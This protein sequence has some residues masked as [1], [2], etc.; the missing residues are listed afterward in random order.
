MAN[1][2]KFQ[3]GVSIACAETYFT[4]CKKLPPQVLRDEITFREKFM[5]DPTARGLNYERIA[6][7]DDTLRSVRVNGSYRAIVKTPS[8]DAKNVYTLLW[9][10]SHDEA[11]TWASKKHIG[12]NSV[13]NAIEIYDVAEKENILPNIV[14]DSAQPKLFQHITDD[15][16]EKLGIAINLIWIIRAAHS[17]GDLEKIKSFLPSQAFEYLTYLN[18]GF[19]IEEIIEMAADKPKEESSAKSYEDAVILQQNSKKFYIVDSDESATELN[20]VL[21]APLEEWRI[22]LHP[23]QKAIV[24]KS[25][26]GPA[27]IL[28]GAGTGKTVVAMH[29]A[30]WLAE[31][32]CAK[33]SDKIL[34]TTFTGNLADDIRA[35]LKLL[36][37]SKILEK[38]EV[39][40]LDKWVFDF[41]KKNRTGERLV[42]GAE[43][44]DYWQKAVNNTD[45]DNKLPI[46]FYMDE[47]E[48]IV[49]ATEITSFEEYKASKRVGR[50]IALNRSQKAEVWEVIQTFKALSANAKIIDSANAM[51]KAKE[52][53]TQSN[54]QLPY[55][56]VI[57]DEAQDF[58]DPSYKL[59]RAI[60]GAEQENDIFIVGDAHQ[61][62]YG[63]KVIL[64]NCGINTVGRSG[65]L[66]INYRTTEEIRSFA[67]TMIEGMIIDDLNDGIDDA[68]GYVSFTHGKPPVK[69]NFK[70]QDDE[71]AAIADQV[72]K[73]LALGFSPESIC[74]VARMNKQLDNLR[75][76]LQQQG[77]SS[78]EIKN[79][80]TDERDRNGIRIATMHRVKGLEFDCVIIADVND[81]I[82]PLDAVLSTATDNINKKEL[83]D[84]ERLLVYVAA[85]RAKKEL[86]LMSYG[87]PSIFL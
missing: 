80:K 85:T 1:L 37:S 10:D 39:V 28:G 70:S 56:A 19:P 6:A 22:F 8:K 30:K 75:S 74:L 40:H 73:W 20:K 2:A 32:F 31:N 14:T 44:R 24:T 35:N 7:A 45:V 79:T 84:A 54:Q 82:V 83:I 59:I 55:K 87:K 58:G 9:I 21:D 25:F 60:A 65:S 46:E 77:F 3:N 72:K 63:K 81:G 34:F 23:A 57:V 76:F 66:K 49:L 38:I 52:I 62:V 53:I 33:Q 78:Y 50:G 61:R 27:C 47:Y 69:L 43:L 67:N 36:C 11:Y 86:V 68:K 13:T 4:A 12:V 26:N 16:F 64:K 5:K 15:H 48:R 18:A 29:R 41:L 17:W 42:Y 71:Y 51:I